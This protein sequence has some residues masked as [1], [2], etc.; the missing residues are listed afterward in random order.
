[1]D[2]GPTGKYQIVKKSSYHFEVQEEHKYFYCQPFRPYKEF[3]S[4]DFKLVKVFKTLGAARR[5]KKECE[6]ITQDGD[7]I[8]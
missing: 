3:Y 1:M 4:S 8:E 7:V 5:F 2:C 6:L